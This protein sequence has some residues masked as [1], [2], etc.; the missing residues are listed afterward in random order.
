MSFKLI[1]NILGLAAKKKPKLF[2]PYMPFKNKPRPFADH[3]WKTTKGFTKE[4][5]ALSK[6]EFIL[7]RAKRRKL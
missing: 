4:E 6:A 3:A 5:K 1:A 2:K 7:Q